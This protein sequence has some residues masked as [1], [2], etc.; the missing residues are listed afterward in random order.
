MHR[1]TRVRRRGEFSGRAIR[2][3]PGVEGSKPIRGGFAPA[4]R[5]SQLETRDTRSPTRE[6]RRPAAALRTAAPQ[7]PRAMAVSRRLCSAQRLFSGDGCFRSCDGCH[8][9]RSQSRKPFIAIG[10]IFGTQYEECVESTG[11]VGEFSRR[12]TPTGA[13]WDNLGHSPLN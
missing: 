6:D 7:E 5:S 4:T 11:S 13:H 2:I 8:P 3:R 1:I 10:T 12:K 9:S